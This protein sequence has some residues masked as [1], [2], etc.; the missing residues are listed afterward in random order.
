[1]TKR[2]EDY[3]YIATSRTGFVQQ[4]VCSYVKNGYRFFVPGRVPDGKDPRDVDEKLLSRYGIRKTDAQRYRAKKAG[5]ANLQYIRFERDWL[6]LATAGS[7]RWR[8]EEAGNI[9]DCG[10]G[11]PIHFQGYSISLKRGLYRPHR[12]KLDR[13]GPAE[14]DDK[15]LVRVQIERE[16]YRELRDEMLSICRR[17]RPAW[18]TAKFYNVPFEPYAP[19]RQ[20]LLK[21]LFNVNQALKRSGRPK[22]S[23]KVIRYTRQIVKPFEPVS[24]VALDEYAA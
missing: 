22:V 9:R 21:I 16:A 1:M 10:A 24:E 11:Q 15:L 2:N 4:V 8:E 7:H 5:K 23:T 17:R 18:L 3:R 6:M 14:R 19:V 13:N 20:Q 12:C